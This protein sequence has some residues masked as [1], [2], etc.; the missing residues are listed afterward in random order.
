VLLPSGI[1]FTSDATNTN[2]GLGAVL[3]QGGYGLGSNGNWGGDRI[4]AGVDSANNAGMVFTMP[5]LV[6][7]V[8]A[9]M[10]YC[11]NCGAAGGGVPPVAAGGTF[12]IIEAIDSGGGVLESYDLFT[13]APINTPGGFNASEFRG[14]FRDAGDIAALRVRGSYLAADDV[15]FTITEPETVTLLGAGLGLLLLLRRQW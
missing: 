3:G 7:G 13:A 9:L 12:A 14:I 6:N 4:Y 11:P 10:N 15:T 8:G 2:F 5:F 1:V